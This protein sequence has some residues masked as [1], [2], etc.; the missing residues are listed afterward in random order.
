MGLKHDRTGEAELWPTLLGGLRSEP[1]VAGAGR[2]ERVGDGLHRRLEP[3]VD[4]PGQLDQRLAG[5]GLGLPPQL[6][7][8]LGQRHVLGLWVGEA[9]DA[10][11]AVRAAAAVGG[12]VPFEHHHL[13]A[14]SGQPPRGGRPVDPR[15]HHDCIGPAHHGRPN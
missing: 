15:P 6:Q 3:A 12:G 9:E 11:T 4:P 5:L 10:H 14:G 7:C 1:L 2:V 13:A 8:P